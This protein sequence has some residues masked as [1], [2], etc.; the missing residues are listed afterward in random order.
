VTITFDHRLVDGEMGSKFLADV[1][2][3]MSDPALALLF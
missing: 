3:I 2:T 1:S